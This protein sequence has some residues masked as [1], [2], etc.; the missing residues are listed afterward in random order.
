[1]RGKC[2]CNA[3]FSGEDCKIKE[4]C[5]K[6]CSNHGI[7]LGSVCLCKLGWFGPIC[8]IKEKD[9]IPCKN[10]CNGN[11]ICQNDDCICRKGFSGDFCEREAQY[12]CPFLKFTN[13]DRYIL[14]AG[15]GICKSGTCYCFPGFKV[16]FYE[17]NLFTREQAVMKKKLVPMIA[18]EMVFAKMAY[19]PVIQIL[20]EMTVQI[21]SL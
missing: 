10:D 4:T 14:C 5:A 18:M 12:E 3:G 7:C 21:Q 6:N 11:G 16:S 2:F 13:P 20:T 8:N 19:V 9:F 15:N 17:L 1:M